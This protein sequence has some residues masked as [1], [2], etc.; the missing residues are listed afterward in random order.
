MNRF[1]RI[2]VTFRF[3]PQEVDLVLDFSRPEQKGTSWEVAVR[4]RAGHLF[5]RR[6]QLLTDP[7]AGN[8]KRLIDE[9]NALGIGD[10]A[11]LA[12]LF[13]EVTESVLASHRTG[14]PAQD[15]IGEMHR[16][17]PPAWAS[18]G[19]LLKNKPNCW[20]GAASTGKSTLAKAICTY[21]A[22]GYR[23][24]DREMEQ[25]VAMYLDWEDDYDS[26]ARTVYDICANLGVRDEWP[27]LIYVDMHGSR[28]RDR[29]ESLARDIHRRH[30][31][32][33]VLDA[34]AA[35]GA[36]PDEHVT[37]EMIALE[38]ADCLDSLPPVTVLALDH[39]TGEESKAIKSTRRNG[40]MPN[41]PTK[42]RGS[43]RKL[44]YFRN[45]WTL[46][47]D[48][49]AEEQGR[50]V[51]NWD[52]TKLN[53]GKLERPGF[54]TEILHY[55]EEI[56]IIV[57]AREV[58]T[59]EQPP[60]DD[61]KGG[62]LLRALGAYWR[63]PRELAEEVDARPPTEARIESVRT[64]LNR[65]AGKGLVDKSSSSPVR[66]RKRCLEVDGNVV[67]FPESQTPDPDIT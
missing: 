15:M 5:T 40:F 59:F 2:G 53:L 63:T 55:P 30:V 54:A 36:V 47:A 61:T 3:A 14:H 9:V 25:G 45:Q 44:E 29:V 37:Y 49:Q 26:F 48:A 10:A 13:L 52:H 7:K 41:V 39:V 56:S 33:L 16:P 1:E 57:R 18:Q 19:L 17:P 62:N 51:V 31:G 43:V 42:G 32:L 8:T 22:T 50:H 38:M 21:Y 35:M 58:Y 24:C 65:F 66:Y 23:F 46:T 11:L 34:V 12:K 20:L 4:R 64:T 6:I 27:P 28:L 60:D 67:S